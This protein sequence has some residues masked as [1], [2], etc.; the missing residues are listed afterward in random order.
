MTFAAELSVHSL[1]PPAA[2]LISR[3]GAAG[4]GAGAVTA[5]AAVRESVTLAEQNAFEA[6]GWELR[7]RGFPRNKDSVDC[8]EGA[9]HRIA[10][11]IDCVSRMVIGWAMEGPR[12][13]R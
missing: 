2:R 13:Y 1:R 10:T 3:G 4:V 9:F 8:D 6:L 11:V 12:T 5:G 7:L